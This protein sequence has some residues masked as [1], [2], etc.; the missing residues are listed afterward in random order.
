MKLK[1]FRKFMDIEFE[2]M[3][4]YISTYGGYFISTGKYLDIENEECDPDYNM[5]AAFK[6]AFPLASID[7]VFF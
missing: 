3:A 6:R 1:E 5:M 7:K 2:D 4:T